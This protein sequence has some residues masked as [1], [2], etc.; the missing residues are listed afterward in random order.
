VVSGYLTSHLNYSGGD[1]VSSVRLMG[2]KSR[3][4]G[5]HYEREVGNLW[6]RAGISFKRN[7]Q[8]AGAD[9]Q[10]PD[11]EPVTPL[12]FMS[13]E[14][15]TV[16]IW[17]AHCLWHECKRRAK[18]FSTPDIYR[19]LEEASAPAGRRGLLPSVTLR[20]DGKPSLLVINLEDLIEWDMK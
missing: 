2:R 1:L 5:A 11:I 7:P 15:Q 4:K 3:T 12:P 18:Q 14:I 8:G 20:L 19:A 16:R 9:R 6:K 17:L 13:T 10:G